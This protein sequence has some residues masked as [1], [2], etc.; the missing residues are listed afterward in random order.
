VKSEYPCIEKSKKVKR[1]N[2]FMQSLRPVKVYHVLLTA[3]ILALSFTLLSEFFY[4]EAGFG[5]VDYG[6]PLPWKRVY[7]GVTTIHNYVNLTVDFFVWTIV[8]FVLLVIVF[9]FGLGWKPT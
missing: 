3:G 5:W 6:F 9:K 2:K 4:S 1:L 8:I 7:G